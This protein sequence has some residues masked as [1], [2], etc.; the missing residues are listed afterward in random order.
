MVNPDFYCDVLRPLRKRLE[1]QHNH[2]SLLHHDN[3]PAHVLKIAE[4]VTKNN[5]VITPHPPY[6]PD[7]AVCDFTLFPKVKMKLEGDISK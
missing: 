3:T 1:L 6:S 5:V 4:F 2:N 7:L